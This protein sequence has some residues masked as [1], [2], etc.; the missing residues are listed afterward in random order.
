MLRVLL[1]DDVPQFGDLVLQILR[2][3]MRDVDV[4]QELTCKDGL[5][6][7]GMG[8]F[9]TVLLDQKLLDIH[10][11]ECLREIRDI[12]KTLPV[13]MVTAFATNELM[14]DC[15]REGADDFVPKDL[16]DVLL[17]HVVWSATRRRTAKK[18]IEQE[19]EHRKKTLD[20][21]EQRLGA[22]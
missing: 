1:I 17:P 2:K 10:G 18:R 14:E 19:V 7:L 9:D 12:T 15:M 11:L 5:V 3:T 6:A 22:R 21:M 8:E 13:I 20:T 4:R 16:M